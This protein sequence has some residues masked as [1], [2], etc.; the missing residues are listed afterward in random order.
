MG[1]F[2]ESNKKNLLELWQKIFN[3]LHATSSYAEL[4]A[5]IYLCRSR[6]YL[7]EET[8]KR[9]LKILNK[10]KG[11][12][13]PFEQGIAYAVVLSLTSLFLLMPYPNICVMSLFIILFHLILTIHNL[14]FASRITCKRA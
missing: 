14:S 9:N 7:N 2:M 1:S 12:I 4:F 6:S 11:F 5:C 3:Q 13:V 10:H 8:A